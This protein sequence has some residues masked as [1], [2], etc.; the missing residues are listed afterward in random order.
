MGK[1]RFF[2]SRSKL[3]AF[4]VSIP[5]THIYDMVG[6]RGE[7]RFCECP[8]DPFHDLFSTYS[9]AYIVC[10]VSFIDVWTKRFLHHQPAALHVSFSTYLRFALLS[11]DVRRCHAD[12]LIT[13]CP[14]RNLNGE[15]PSILY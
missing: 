4:P 6:T 2:A 5:V 14:E 9:T 13:D 8:C 15:R 10:L 11:A 7:Y 1:H 3:G 12:G